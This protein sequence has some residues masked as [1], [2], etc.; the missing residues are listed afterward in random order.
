M[1]GMTKEEIYRVVN[2]Y[3]GV[4]AGYLVGFSYASH[5]EFY[6]YFCGLDIDPLKLEGM[7]T[8]QRFMKILDEAEPL[9][10]AKIL[11]GTLKKCPP[12]PEIPHRTQE[13][14][15]EIQRI[16]SRIEGGPSV[17]SPSPKITSDVVERA[18]KDA[19]TLIE[20]SG[21]TSGVDRVHTALH[22]YL[23]AVCDG[24]GIAYG[25]D[26]GITELFKLLKQNHPKLQNVGPRSAEITQVLRSL[27]AILDALNPVRNRA[28]VAHP[29][30]ALL[31]E[32]EAM[33]II[34]VARTILH[35][36]DAKFS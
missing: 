31:E 20:K 22:G 14:A 9:D 8:R 7:T 27:S 18:I 28:S 16:I 1:K 5:Q 35:Y 13:R 30:I 15:D 34:N 29:N 6:P 3:I 25:T 33:L 32:D 36:L 17:V 12:T 11:R 19:E 23:K 21:A 2:D 24:Q 10:Q 4:E 26:A